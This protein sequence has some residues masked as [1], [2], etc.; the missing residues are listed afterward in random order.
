[1][2][3]QPAPSDALP[4]LLRLQQVG[5]ITGLRRSMIY[6]LE[7]DGNFPRR[8]KLATRAAGWV[9]SEIRA[10][11][12]AR[13]MIRD[14]FKKTCGERDS[15]IGRGLNRISKL[16]NRVVARVPSDPEPRIYHQIC[17]HPQVKRGWCL[18]VARYCCGSA[19]RDALNG[20]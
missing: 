6:Q 9:E 1:M 10:W 19:S 7:A 5:E 11:I 18:H 15:N 8:V 3:A 20:T 2:N 12:A 13:I 4:R 14:G 16:L 17:Q